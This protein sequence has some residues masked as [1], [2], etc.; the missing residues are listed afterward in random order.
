METCKARICICNPHLESYI[1]WN[2]FKRCDKKVF[3]ENLCRKCFEDDKRK[4]APKYHGPRWKRDGIYGQ[5]Y[6]FPYHVLE[7]DK[8]WVD[9][10]YELHP[11]IKPKKDNEL[12]KEH[13]QMIDNIKQ[14]IE[15][16]S[17]NISYEMVHELSQIIHSNT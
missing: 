5:P 11:S 12:A 16:F 15:K 6:D 10:I 2:D 13:E 7:K 8:K 1:K 4:W 3:K 9:M 17:K 14:W